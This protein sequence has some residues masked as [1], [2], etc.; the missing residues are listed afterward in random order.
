LR[1]RKVSTKGCLIKI[2]CGGFRRPPKNLK[3][4]VTDKVN[5]KE[6]SF[7]G[8]AKLVNFSPQL[9]PMMAFAA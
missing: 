4:K 3:I 2:A 6:M 5:T 9:A 7:V 1:G 8:D